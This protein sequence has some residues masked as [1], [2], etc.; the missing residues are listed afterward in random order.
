M[1]FLSE[2]LGGLV[3]PAESMSNVAVR[4]I[5]K[6]VP[7]TPPWGSPLFPML[8]K[9]VSAGSRC[10]AATTVTD[11]PPILFSYP[12]S[13]YWAAAFRDSWKQASGFVVP[14]PGIFGHCTFQTYQS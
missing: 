6:T 14:L 11:S 7:K 2:F 12:N 1:K 8:L 4:V 13:W 5:G 10:S 9:A 3:K